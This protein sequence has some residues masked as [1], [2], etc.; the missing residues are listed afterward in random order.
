MKVLNRLLE[1][2][3]LYRQQE[4]DP[5]TM[6]LLPDQIVHR[7]RMVP[8]KKEENRI[9]VAT[10]NTLD[11]AALDDVR[12][13]T[14]CDIV[15]VETAGKDIDALI[16]RYFGLPEVKSVLLEM[17]KNAGS[18]Q[19]VQNSEETGADSPVV[20]LVNALILMAV[21]EE[22]SDIHIEPFKEQVLVRFR[23]DGVLY[24]RFHLP[25]KMIYPLVSRLKVMANLDITERRLPQD[26]R[27]PLA[28]PGHDLDLRVSIVPTI[29]GE[30]VVIRIFDKDCIKNYTLENLNFSPENLHTMREFLKKPYGLVL[31]TGPTG[32]GKSTTLYTALKSIC[33]VERNIVTVEDP[34]EYVLEGVNQTQIN[35]KAGAN[36]ATYLR[37][38]LRQDPDVIMIGEIRDLETAEIA[39]RAATTGHLGLSTMHTN[40]AP[41][42][43]TRLVDMGVEPFMVASTVLGVVAQRL[44]RRVCSHCQENRQLSEPE[45]VF[46]GVIDHQRKVR[47]GKGCS[48]CSY[49][50]YRG[51]VALHEILRVTPVMHKLILQRAPASEL[52]SVALQEN[53]IPLKDDGIWKALKG[54]TSIQ[55]I[56]RLTG[57]EGKPF[58][59][60][61]A[62]VH[63]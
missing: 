13:L 57:E 43:L 45:L 18:D 19:V 49:T 32:S 1:V 15:P 11:V 37:S 52:R 44:V 31:V 56:M 53:M 34:V 2:D 54:I 3:E 35:T 61:L 50:G 30:K 58:T 47:S 51:R 14:G 36:F 48:Q 63:G 6:K 40:D 16:T 8:L 33:S 24:Q 27:I 9:F 26:G 5:E 55:E 10:P 29:F 4:F 60:P 20:R 42:A 28:L 39:V 17:S 7:Y 59:I 12:M 62:L 38:I 21:D 46:S 22:A 25:F 41:G 23:V